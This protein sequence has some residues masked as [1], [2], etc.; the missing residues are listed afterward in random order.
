ML[1]ARVPQYLA[2]QPLY[3]D[4]RD[5]T[6]RLFVESA[7]TSPTGPLFVDVSGDRFRPNDSVSRLTAAIALVRAAGLRSDAEARAGIPLTFLDAGSIPEVYSGYVSVAISRGL[8][9]GDT[10]FRP[11]AALTR[12]ELAH[13]I[14]VIERRAVE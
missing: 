13:A 12:V 11:Q 5:S 4:V 14:A 8:L 9:Q 10:L 3:Q 2:G 7:Q 1:G 6:T